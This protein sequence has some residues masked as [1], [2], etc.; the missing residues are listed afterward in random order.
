MDTKSPKGENI[1]SSPIFKKFLGKAEDYLNKPLRVKQLL[2]D[3][4]HKATE[5][6]DLGSIAHEAWE[7]LQV[8]MRLI[9]TSV[10]GEYTGLPTPTIVAAVAVVIYFLSPIDFIPDF[11]PV[12]GLLDDVALLAWF[13]TSLKDEMDKFEAWEKS[14]PATSGPAVD[15]RPSRAVALNTSS[16]GTTGASGPQP[17]GNPSSTQGVESTQSGKLHG[18]DDLKPAEGS[19]SNTDS[20][21]GS[22]ES[23]NPN[24]SRTSSTDPA[25]NPNPGLHADDTAKT[26]DGSR[27]HQD[28]VNDSGGNV[29]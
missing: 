14:R 22:P 21:L 13:T 24:P 17:Q 28:N 9:R 10:S 4:Y 29:R 7:S 25:P 2:N 15:L 27:S 5:K 23:S 3:A 8:L 18:K 19:I 6:K 12:I 11:F 26:T 1:A 16:D 20:G